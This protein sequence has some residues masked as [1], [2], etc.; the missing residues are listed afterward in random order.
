MHSKT[1]SSHLRHQ[2]ILVLMSIALVAAGLAVFFVDG[3]SGKEVAA[4]QAFA[5]FHYQQCLRGEPPAEP[6]VCALRTIQL[7]SVLYGPPFAELVAEQIR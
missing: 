4:A 5:A 2:G 1:L 6:V 7:A 3:P